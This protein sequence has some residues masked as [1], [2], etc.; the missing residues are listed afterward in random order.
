V[1]N[2]ENEK[3]SL[4]RKSSEGMNKK[5]RAGTADGRPQ[6]TIPRRATK[7]LKIGLKKKKRS[8]K[9]RRGRLT[10]WER[11]WQIRDVGGSVAKNAEE[12]LT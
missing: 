9:A 6:G 3:I 8:K 10:G 1:V 2:A 7:T 11:N 12:G 4:L 5:R